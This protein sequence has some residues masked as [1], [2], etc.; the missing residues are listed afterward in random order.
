[1]EQHH[2]SS[3]KI[4]QFLEKNSFVTKVN[5]PGLASHPNHELAVRQASGHSGLMSFCIKGGLKE[6]DKFVDNLKLIQLAP[7]LG[8]VESLVAVPVQMTHYMISQ[9]KRDKMGITDSLIRLSVGIENADDLISDIEQAL[10][11]TYM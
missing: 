11:T 1:M 5:H 2:K 4:A 8:G 9:E 6:V 3:M 7:S 10:K